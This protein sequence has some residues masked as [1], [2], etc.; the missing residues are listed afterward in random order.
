M[1]HPTPRN[2]VLLLQPPSITPNLKSVPTLCNLHS[3]LQN[4]L[5]QEVQILSA[6]R[7]C[8]ILCHGV[9]IWPLGGAAGRMH[10][11]IFWNE[12]MRWT[13]FFTSVNKSVEE[14]RLALEER[15][16]M[17]EEK[18]SEEQKLQRKQQKLQL[19]Q[20]RMQ[21]A[22]GTEIA[23]RTEEAARIGWKRMERG[24]SL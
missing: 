15:K 12:S 24:E 8:Q 2:S 22:G 9:K 19:A 7:C 1:G 21:L 6:A 10:S 18:R 23:A 17:L 16:I 20:Q 14:K 13:E 3:Y 5:R 4:K 11:L